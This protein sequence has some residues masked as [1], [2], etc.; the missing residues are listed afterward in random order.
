MKNTS[1]DKSTGNFTS[2]ILL[3]QLEKENGNYKI[4]QGIGFNLPGTNSVREATA[5]SF[6][7]DLNNAILNKKYDVLSEHP[8]LYQDKEEVVNLAG[9]VDDHV[10]LYAQWKKC[11]YTVRYHANGGSGTMEDQYFDYGEQKE[12]S[13]NKFLPPTETQKFR[14]WSTDPNGKTGNVYSNMQS[15]MNLTDKN[16]GVVDLYAQWTNDNTKY[17]LIYDANGGEGT[18]DKE[19]CTFGKLHTLK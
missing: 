14:V 2:K 5:G 6:T 17:T 16:G 18:M 13:E 8:S 10:T 1:L 4:T 15:V 19:I 12:L 9:D 7:Y 11:S 3:S